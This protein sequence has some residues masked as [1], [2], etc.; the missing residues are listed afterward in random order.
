MKY[1]YNL[2][3]REFNS[4]KRNSAEFNIYCFNH[5]SR[6]NYEHKLKMEMLFHG[7]NFK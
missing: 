3:N 1:K 2:D 7:T 6:P 4:L 5:I